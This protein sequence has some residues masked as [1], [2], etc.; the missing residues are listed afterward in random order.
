[1]EEIQQSEMAASLSWDE[2]DLA[3]SYLVSGLFVEAAALAS[4]ILTRLR[5][6]RHKYTDELLLHEMMESSAMVLV[7][8]WRETG[9]TSDLLNE[10]E[11]YFGS[12]T[13]I[14][15]KVVL[16][17]ACV[18][19][20]GGSP[21]RVRDFL[22]DVLAKWPL[23]NEKFYVL[24][25]LDLQK[26][27]VVVSTRQSTLEVDQY[28]EVVEFYA[29]TLVGG[30]LKDV[31]RA[32]SWVEKAQLP[33]EQRQD[34]LRRL[35]SLHPVETPSSTR[36]AVSVSKDEEPESQP[37]TLKEVKQS[38]KTIKGTSTPH[39]SGV[40]DTKHSIWIWFQTMAQR[41]CISIIASK[42]KIFLGCLIFLI[43]YFIQRKRATLKRQGGSTATVIT[44]TDCSRLLETCI[45]IPSESFGCCST[46]SCLRKQKQMIC[47]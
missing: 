28:L 21:T 16:T 8:S 26:N 36:G 11:C 34:L 38:D 29:L 40:A 3:E 32:V 6:N 2:I 5:D 23:N 33:E 13:E 4:S 39:L 14:P 12:V 37:L 46:P 30:V 45:F 7:Q 44:E 43:C 15:V 35:F 17:G 47:A 18:Q 27:D 24:S 42:G 1:M 20:S 19:V 41:S 25:S 22:E 31:D 9:R 10:L